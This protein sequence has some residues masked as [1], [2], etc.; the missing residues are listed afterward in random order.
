MPL[1][2]S[3]LQAFRWAA[4]GIL[5]DPDSSGRVLTDLEQ[6]GGG[7]GPACAR[8]RR[9]RFTVGELLPFTGWDSEA[10][11]DRFSSGMQGEI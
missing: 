11:W 3:I 5:V 2:Q 1:M 8:V 6:T 7:P 9:R 4:E 10:P